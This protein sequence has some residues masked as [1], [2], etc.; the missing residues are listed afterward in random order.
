MAEVALKVYPRGFL[1]KPLEAQLKAKP[2]PFEARLSSLAVRVD[3]FTPQ[4]NSVDSN[5]IVETLYGKWINRA[6]ETTSFEFRKQVLIAA[7]DAFGTD[8]FFA[9]FG[10]QPLSPAFGD[11]H[12]RFLED[13]LL[14]LKEGRRTMSLENWASLVRLDDAGE[15]N[16]ELSPLAKEFFG[17]KVPDAQY[18]E[19]QNRDLVTIIQKW[20]SHARGFD[21][22][23]STLHVLFGDLI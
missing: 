1:G 6:P 18:R 11:M 5:P 3:L 13:T 10:A 15:R 7:L 14:F 23:V 4:V 22:L 17:V 2:R 16:L 19:P 20:V 21:D 8:S 9:W 12:K